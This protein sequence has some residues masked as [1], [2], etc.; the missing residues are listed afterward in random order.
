MSGNSR[1]FPTEAVTPANLILTPATSERQVFRAIRFRNNRRSCLRSG[2]NRGCTGLLRCGGCRL[3]SHILRR[4]NLTDI[5]C[6]NVIEPASVPLMGVYVKG[7]QNLLPH[8]YVESLQAVN[9]KN[10]KYKFTGIL[11]V[12][13]FQYEILRLPLS[14]L[15][16]STTLR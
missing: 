3:G 15:A 4:I 12:V 7:Y 16:D 14:T 10:R 5:E 11:R 8:L 1:R 2:G 9:A 13:R 6:T